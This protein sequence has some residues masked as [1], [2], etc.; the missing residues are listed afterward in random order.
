MEGVDHDRTAQIMHSDLGA[1]LPA[2]RHLRI[3]KI[4][5]VFAR[6]VIEEQVQFIKV[7]IYKICHK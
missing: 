2:I 3:N 5:L 1:T 6:N 7:R 4:V